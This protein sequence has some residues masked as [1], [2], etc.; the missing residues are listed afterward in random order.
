MITYIQGKLT[1]KSPAYVIIETNGIGYHVNVSLNTYAVIQDQESFKLLTYLHVKEDAHTLYGF[2]DE[3]EK[4]LFSQLISV[5]G[6][7]PNTARMVLSSLPPEE[8]RQA[9]IQENV[10]VIQ[11]IKGI[12]PKS[13]KRLILELKDK[14][15]KSGDDTS[16][17][18]TSAHN[19]LKDEALS[20]L[21]M[22]GFSKSA[23][24]KSISKVVQSSPSEDITVEGLIKL[25][26][27]NI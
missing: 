9:I 1:F 15:M 16:T 27:K 13:A 18:P 6:V 12:G 5:A 26:L 11:S 10:A 7:G 4:V 25:A 3:I 20:A 24:E 21:V 14:V 23:A 2:A 19:T 17:K 8:I 22:L